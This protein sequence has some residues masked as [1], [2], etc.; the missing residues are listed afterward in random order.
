MNVPAAP[1]PDFACQTGPRSGAAKANPMTAMTGRPTQRKNLSRQSLIFCS[2]VA[3]PSVT[4][5]LAPPRRA[6]AHR[7]RSPGSP[8]AGPSAAGWSSPASAERSRS[9]SARRRSDASAI[10]LGHLVAPARAAGRTRA[11][12]RT[13]AP[14]SAC[15]NMFMSTSQRASQHRHEQPDPA[16]RV[17]DRRAHVRTPFSAARVAP[18]REVQPVRRASQWTP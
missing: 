17:L 14:A 3:D 4:G 1:P 18:V 6:A 10:S 2:M 5:A 11:R 7:C 12:R 15:R 9:F 13:P 16:Q 8:S